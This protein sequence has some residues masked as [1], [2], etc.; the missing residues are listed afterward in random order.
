[1]SS[2]AKPGLNTLMTKLV[3]PSGQKFL[4]LSQIRRNLSL[5]HQISGRK[6]FY[7]KVDVIRIEGKDDIKDISG[8]NSST[9]YGITLDGKTLKTPARNHLVFNNYLLAALVASEWDAQTDTR[10]GIQPSTMPFMQLASTAIDNLQ[11]DPSPAQST[12]LSFLPTDCSLFWTKEDSGLYKKQ[13]EK[14]RPI[15]SWL[16]ELFSIELLVA[17]GMTMRLAHPAET[18]RKVKAIIDALV[19][20]KFTYILF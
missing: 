1:M 15:L 20:V 3:I 16:N 6:R 9:L 2:F 7:K 12:C 18:T 8:K 13:E 10:K 4:S 19:R 11:F 17:E 5:H 14:F